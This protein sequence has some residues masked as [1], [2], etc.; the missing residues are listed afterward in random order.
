MTVVFAWIFLHETLNLYS[1]IGILITIL[2]VT[3]VI[4]EKNQNDQHEAEHFNW[5]GIF[6]WLSGCADTSCRCC[7]FKMG[8]DRKPGQ[9]PASALVRLLAGTVV[10]LIWI[11]IRREKIGEWL[12]PRPK[13]RFWE[14]LATVILFWDLY[15][16]L[17]AAIGL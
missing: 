1:W 12:N 16:H 17:D 9:C 4:T 2:G 10:L 6:F 14:I 7:P 8:V 13:I 3:W 5:L 15:C 11:A